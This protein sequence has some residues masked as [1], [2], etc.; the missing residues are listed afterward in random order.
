MPKTATDF[1]KAQSILALLVSFFAFTPLVSGQQNQAPVPVK[2]QHF[3]E[4]NAYVKELKRRYP[5]GK[6]TINLLHIEGKAQDPDLVALN[7]LLKQA[8]FTVQLSIISE[9]GFN[10][11]LEHT[12][13]MLYDE[14]LSV[15]PSED[16]LEAT[17]SKATLLERIKGASGALFGLPNGITL[18]GHF[19]ETGPDGKWLKITKD[20]KERWRQIS[21]GAKISI[22][23]TLEYDAV[24]WYKHIMLH[25][26][27]RLN[28]LAF[29]L[30]E[31]TLLG[32]VFTC[33][34]Y[35]EA[36]TSFKNQGN[37]L[38]S[39]GSTVFQE[40][41]LN[42]PMMYAVGLASNP[43][44]DL[45][46]F[47]HTSELGRRSFLAGLA[48]AAADNYRSRIGKKITANKNAGEKLIDDLSERLGYT[49]EI[50]KQIKEDLY[51]EY[52]DAG[53][54]FVRKSKEFKSS[55]N[56]K[57][58]DPEGQALYERAAEQ[59][60]IAADLFNKRELFLGLF[61]NVYFPTVNNLDLL[62]SVNADSHWYSYAALL[63]TGAVGAAYEGWVYRKEIGEELVRIRYS[64]TRFLMEKV[65]YDPNHPQSF[66]AG[67]KS[68][69]CE[70][71]LGKGAAS[72]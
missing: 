22:P 20:K 7:S 60:K 65:G 12:A 59:L 53:N 31:L 1:R 3:E 34:R 16:R 38:F 49:P 58:L 71:V 50:S 9:A 67:I 11:Q 21:T 54:V 47:H 33:V 35:G 27:I 46:F 48:L 25:D 66:W 4:I 55:F 69:T 2:F 14:T 63:F 56:P 30:S 28:G 44:F 29:H 32:W 37:Y 64:A 70:F 18:A 24:F 39:I 23:A 10:A 43:A 62:A 13:D 17:V 19:Y 45:N 68:T 8:G 6:A 72:R 15:S 36:I 52:L 41:I 26:S 51:Q 40:A 42:V 61:F 5:D 57:S